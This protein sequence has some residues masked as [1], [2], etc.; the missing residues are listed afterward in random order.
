MKT[1][2]NYPRV[3]V[4][5]QGAREHAITWKLAQSHLEPVL[6]ALPGNPGMWEL[7]AKV[8]IPLSEHAKI[9]EWVKAERIDF[10]VIGP[11]Q[12]LAEGL[13]DAL[14]EAGI[15]VF[16]PN[17]AAA[18]LEASKSFAK[19]VMRRAGVP[20]ARYEVFTEVAAAQAFA[21]ALGAPVVIK[22]D[23]LA[24]GKGVVVA[25]TLAEANSAI[26]DM[27][28]GNRFGASGHK[29]VI[30]EFLR[31]TE[32][33]LMYFVDGN[34]VVP[35]I[36]ARDFKRVGDG[37]TGPNTGGMGAFAPVPSFLS[38]NWTAFATERIIEPTVQYLKSEGITYRGVLYA[39]L[40]VTQEGP[41]VIEFNARFGD[42]ETEVV[43]PLLETDLLEIMW[44]VAH[45]ELGELDV[46]WHEKAAVCV[47]LAGGEYPA[48][49]DSGTPIE[50]ASDR[51]SGVYVFH[52]GTALRGDQLVTAGGRVLTV[53]AVA[54][55]IPAAIELVYG[56]LDVARFSGMQYRRDI[57]S[58][59]QQ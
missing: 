49:S 34:T 15:P 52:A 24:A 40:M 12:P 47:V 46:R 39:G 1:L 42:P 28:E 5:G 32:V 18:Q 20:T 56:A 13:V 50:L 37:D 59:W 16:G 4:I 41:K 27:L 21:A 25:Q 48:K 14:Q 23:G 26:A 57:A 29:V 19:D 17:R 9:V 7:A 31:G 30:E 22:A 8:D 54:Q 44:A 53:S 11:E 3:A 58:H 45:D 6:Y 43:L 51:P 10:V 38:A 36:P 2:G 55:D 35:M 33:S